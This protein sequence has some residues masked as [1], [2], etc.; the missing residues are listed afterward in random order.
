MSTA[1]P[2]LEPAQL[3][4]LTHAARAAAGRAY[5]P[6]SHFQVGAALLFDDQTMFTGCNV[7]NASYGLTCC[8]ERNALFRS[9]SERG[10]GAKILAVIVTNLAQSA[11]PPCGACLQVLSEFVADGAVVVFENG[12]GQQRVLF[13]ELMPFRFKLNS[14]E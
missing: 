1:P 9:V 5:A 4:A 14:D 13:D 11:C 10:A 6:Y 3:E 8:A 7:E 12:T 2:V